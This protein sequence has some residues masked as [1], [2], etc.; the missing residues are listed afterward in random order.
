MSTLGIDGFLAGCRVAA[1]VLLVIAVVTG[2]GGPPGQM[3]SQDRATP[4]DAQSV[5]NA[6]PNEAQFC[7]YLAPEEHTYVWRTKDGDLPTERQLRS[8]DDLVLEQVSTKPLPDALVA[9][10]DVEIAAD[11]ITDEDTARRIVKANVA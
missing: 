4:D 3:G 1:C 10:L 6:A 5:E 7:V 8:K 2:C 9:V 11:V